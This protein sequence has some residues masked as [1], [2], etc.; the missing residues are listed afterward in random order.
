MRPRSYTPDRWVLIE[1]GTPEEM[2]M[3]VLGG[4]Y[5]GFA[6]ANSWKLSSGT[7]SVIEHEDRLEMP[8]YSGS[9]Y[10][11]FK[12][13][14]GLSSLTAAT[15]AG[16]KKDVEQI[17]AMESDKPPVTIRVLDEAEA[18]AYRG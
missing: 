7:T 3:K 13:S 17:N 4:F 14:Y 6:G 5:G 8:Q 1:I 9:T 10:E 16:F 11:C 2:T 15:L 12:N 18:L